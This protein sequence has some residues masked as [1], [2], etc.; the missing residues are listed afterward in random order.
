MQT[1]AQFVASARLRSNPLRY[2][3]G[4]RM[5]ELAA[6]PEHPLP[7]ETVV[8][9]VTMRTTTYFADVPIPAPWDPPPGSL[10]ELPPPLGAANASAPL[11]STRS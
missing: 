6:T 1:A 11:I 8:E 10:A 5:V 2:E 4:T 3:R 7:N 9:N